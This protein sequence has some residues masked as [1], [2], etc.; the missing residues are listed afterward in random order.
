MGD[1][2]ERFQ[3]AARL[4]VANQKA[5]TSYLQTRLAMGFAK[6]ARVMGQLEAAGIVGPQEGAKPR[7]VLIHDNESLD[8]LLSNL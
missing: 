8:E 2:D 5:S 1:L 4:V 6:A 7:E 3:E